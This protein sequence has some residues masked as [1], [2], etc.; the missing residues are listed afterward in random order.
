MEILLE[1]FDMND[2]AL[3]PLIGSHSI[4]KKIIL[5]LY[6]EPLQNI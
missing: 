1:V 4:G 3:N 6:I 5:K 2:F